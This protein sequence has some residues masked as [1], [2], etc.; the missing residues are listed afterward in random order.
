[1]AL[2]D[3]P[4]PRF[5]LLKLSL[6]NTASMQFSTAAPYM[7]EFCDIIVMFG[8][9]P[10]MKSVEQIGLAGRCARRV[11]QVFVDDNLIGNRAQ[12]KVLL[13]FS[14]TTRRSDY[15]FGFGTEASSIW[16]R[17]RN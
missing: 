4:T 11:R 9:R 14:P 7:Y 10:R 17:T 6:Y 3:S 16:R 1:M 12:A 8:R 5:D 15:R 13:R 2:T